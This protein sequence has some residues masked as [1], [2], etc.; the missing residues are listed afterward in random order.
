[1]SLALFIVLREGPSRVM[2]DLEVPWRAVEYC[3]AAIEQWRWARSQASSHHHPATRL[4][5]AE[6]HRL[7]MHRAP[8]LQALCVVPHRLCK[9][10]RR[11][12]T[13]IGCNRSGTIISASCLVVICLD[14]SRSDW[15]S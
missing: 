3:T 13:A 14:F 12:T 9:S 2:L 6:R 5:C 4:Q 7:Q 10:C 8:R 1:M 15:C 11:D